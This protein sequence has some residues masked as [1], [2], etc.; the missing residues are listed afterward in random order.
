MDSP[1]EIVTSA[2]Q[3]EDSIGESHK[4]AERIAIGIREDAALEALLDPYNK[5]EIVDKREVQVIPQRSDN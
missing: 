4:N 3:S 1:Q 5:R 2:C